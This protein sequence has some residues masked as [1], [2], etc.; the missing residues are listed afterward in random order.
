MDLW[1][2]VKVIGRHW[3]L[4]VLALAL[5][6]GVGGG[7]AV[8]LPPTYSAKAT[9]LL[10]PPTAGG[11]YQPLPQASPQT[12]VLP[13]R[14]Y[15]PYLSFDSSLYVL[16]SVV[17]QD[18]TSDDMKKRI[19]SEGAHAKY[20]MTANGNEPSVT[21][22]ATDQDPRQVLI[23]M[24]AVVNHVSADLTNRQRPTGIPEQNWVT[25]SPLDLPVS[26]QETSTKLK[27]IGGVVGLGLLG[28]I[29]LDFVAESFGLGLRL[30][31]RTV[32]PTVAARE[33]S[34]YSRS[35]VSV[36][37]EAERGSSGVYGDRQPPAEAASVPEQ[38]E[39]ASKFG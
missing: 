7:L 17:A 19:K 37:K 23:T 27:I 1:N 39:D 20:E 6:A 26:A 28:A 31:R 32:R 29:S 8:N 38:R 5:V 4:L 3:L 13:P 22:I 12:A 24:D 34:P 18:L 33:T 9:V 16:A 30:R 36:A 11:A 15:N 21:V 25:A 35:P 10:L 2:A 14:V